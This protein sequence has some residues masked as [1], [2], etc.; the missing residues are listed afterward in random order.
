ME[1]LFSIY[2]RYRA[3]M[4]SEQRKRCSALNKLIS[5]VHFS[6]SLVV[7]TVLPD[8]LVELADVRRRMEKRERKLTFNA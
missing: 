3:A 8:Y 4:S 5:A 2:K 1:N 7:D 6:Q